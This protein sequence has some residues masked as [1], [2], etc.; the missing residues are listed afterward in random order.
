MV[1]STDGCLRSPC[2]AIVSPTVTL[3]ALNRAIAMLTVIAAFLPG[4][5]WR[6]EDVKNVTSC[7]STP[8]WTLGLWSGKAVAKRTIAELTTSVAG[9]SGRLSTWSSELVYKHTES[10]SCAPHIGPMS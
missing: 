8:S 2:S 6:L 3:S 10:C 1:L 9:G 5:R 7:A 4:S